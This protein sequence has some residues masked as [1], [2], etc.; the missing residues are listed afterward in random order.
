MNTIPPITTLPDPPSRQDPANF[1]TR[2]DAFMGALPA[3]ARELNAVGEAINSNLAAIESAVANAGISAAPPYDNGAMYN[4]PDIVAGSDGYTYRCKGTNVTGD[5]PV[6]SGTGNWVSLTPGVTALYN[7]V[8]AKASAYTALTT[9]KGRMFKCTGTWTFGLPDAALAGNGW[10]IVVKNDGTGTITVNGLVLL[11]GEAV[12][13][14]SDGANWK[15]S[16]RSRDT[17]LSPTEP[18]YTGITTDANYACISS[19]PIAW[20]MHKS[21][22]TAKAAAM[23]VGLLDGRFLQ[24]GGH[25][26]TATAECH[27]FDPATE[28]WTAKAALTGARYRACIARLLDGTVF[29]TC[30]ESDSAYFSSSYLY[31]PTANT[32]TAKASHPSAAKAGAACC[33]LADG[34]VLVVGGTTNGTANTS[35][36][37][38]W[39]PTTNVWTAKAA[40]PEAKRYA[41]AVL[42]ANG[43]VLV[44]GGYTT[45]AVATA[46]VYNPTTNVWSAVAGLPVAMFDHGGGRL[47]DGRVLVVGGSSSSAILSSCYLYDPTANVWLTRQSLPV[48]CAAAAV[49]T[50]ADGRVMS[51]GGSNGTADLSTTY[52]LETINTWKR[53]A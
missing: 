17:A 41:L 23:G 20:A 25:T 40:H 42:L 45:T 52:I 35:E 30:G 12:A 7:T 51:V 24:V 11:A 31:S 39:D 9:D 22:P 21:I 47:A 43:N 46:H 49:G 37:H 32:W 6:G 36:C 16:A 5:N 33:T 50:L 1:S 2:G 19:A 8:V 27:I 4:Y 29:V 26:S 10:T 34:R 18:Y 15:S 44:T 38:I 14:T 28:N 3:L 48:A 53:A 13:L